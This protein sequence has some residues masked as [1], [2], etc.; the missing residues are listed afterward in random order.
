MKKNILEYDALDA[1]PLIKKWEDLRLDAY[2]CPAGVPTIGY[3][4]TAGVRM[5]DRITREKAERL[6]EE[7]LYKFQDELSTL[8]KV[9]VTVGQFIALMS[10]IFN[11]GLT[12]CR[13]Y[14][15]FKELNKGNYEGAAQWFP[16]YCAP[17]TKQENGLRARRLEEQAAFLRQS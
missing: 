9:P 7:D 11:F 10:F 6:L 8:V 2:R 1:A 4:H 15:L 5:G 17:G 12:K 13:S 16:K 3:G 14:S